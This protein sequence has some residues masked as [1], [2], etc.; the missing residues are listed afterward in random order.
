MRGSCTVE[1]KVLAMSTVYVANPKDIVLNLLNLKN[2]M[3]DFYPRTPKQVYHPAVAMF[4]VSVT[5]AVLDFISLAI[6]H[7]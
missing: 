1:Y 5:L 7:C 3:I 2:Y 4:M 6:C